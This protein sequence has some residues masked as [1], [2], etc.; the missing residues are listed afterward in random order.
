MSTSAGQGQAPV[1]ARAFIDGVSALAWSAL[2]DGSLDF[3]NGRFREYTGLASEQLYGSQWKSAVHRDD[4]QALET[5]WQD[6]QQSQKAGTT[7]VRLR[8]FDGRYRWFQIAAAP[9][10]DG[11]ASLVRWCGINTDIDDLKRSE[12][13]LREE[14]ADLRTITD[15]I[16]Q[17]IVVLA[18]DGTTLYANRVALD[19]TGL[20]AHELS[21][22][23]F[24]ARVFHPED[25]DRV[26]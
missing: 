23:G 26:R 19:Q 7:E 13:K 4:I 10:H 11:Q 1:E 12:L 15:A 17:V 25:I 5:W 18:P 24:F 20:K 9:I 2:P 22:Q 21:D 6:L 14:G 3:I 16:R 8:R